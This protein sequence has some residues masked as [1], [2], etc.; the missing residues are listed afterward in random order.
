MTTAYKCENCGDTMTFD[1]K[2]GTLKCPACEHSIEILDDQSKV[3]EHTLS[4]D[5]KRSIKVEEKET[6]TMECTSC[7]AKVEVSGETT[8]VDCPYCGSSFVLASKQEDA[9]IPDGLVAFKFDQRGASELFGKWINNRFWAPNALK[10]LHQ[11]GKIQGIYLPYWTFD[12][13]VFSRYTARGGK[14]RVKTYRDS[15]GNTRTR[16]YVDWYPTSGH[17]QKFIDDELVPAT[18]KV[19]SNILD[20]L[21]TF[22]TKAVVS[23]SPEYMSGYSAQCYSVD[24]SDAHEVAKDKMEEQIRQLVRRDVLRRYDEVADIRI[25]PVY[26]DETYKHIMLPIYSAAYHYNDKVFN[27]LIN[28][29]TGEVEGEYPKSAVKITIAV[30]LAILLVVLFYVFFGN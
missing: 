11:K 2:S 22:D 17:V 8:A 21:D 23:Y 14:R 25:A 20:K 27:L 30:I 28:G 15:E 4:L 1:P 7:G 12:A 3:V 18:T 24:L 6:H 16:T 26:S 19:S 10:G 5:S 13:Q 9:L 29:Q